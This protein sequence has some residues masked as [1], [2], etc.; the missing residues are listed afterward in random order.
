MNLL[1]YSSILFD[2]DGVILDSNKIKSSSFYNTAARYCEI[3]AKQLLEYHKINGGISRYVKFK[4]FIENILPL[5]PNNSKI[6]NVPSIEN[7]T[8]EYAK[9]LRDKL[10]TCSIAE[11]LNMLRKETA[12]ADWYVI[13][14]GDENEVKEVFKRRNIDQYFDMGI[15]GSPSSKFEIITKLIAEKKLQQPAVFL[16]DSIYDYK[17]AKHFGIDFIFISAWSEVN[18]WEKFVEDNSI[19]HVKKLK[20][21]IKETD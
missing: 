19:N 8:K 21:L 18:N 6:E 20:D 9:E 12:K 2:C 11:N 4:Y 1:N 16:G 17:A 15:Y 5:S 7:L 3:S 14:G 10:D 13:T